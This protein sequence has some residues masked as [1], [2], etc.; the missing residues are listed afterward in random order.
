MYTVKIQRIMAQGDGRDTALPVTVRTV[1]KVP[2]RELAEA[3]AAMWFRYDFVAAVWIE[4][5]PTQSQ[6]WP[7]LVGWAQRLSSRPES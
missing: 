5:Y 7:N 3:F 2:T 6:V 1:G 4:L